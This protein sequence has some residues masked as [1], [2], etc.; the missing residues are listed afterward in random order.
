LLENDHEAFLSVVFD[1]SKK[2]KNTAKVGSDSGGNSN[3]G[4]GYHEGGGNSING[5]GAALSMGS[6]GDDLRCRGPE[7][8]RVSREEAVQLQAEAAAT[9]PSSQVNSAAAAA[10]SAA[11]NTARAAGVS[12]DQATLLD[13]SGGSSGSSVDA[14]RSHGARFGIVSAFARVLAVAAACAVLR[15]WSVAS[16]RRRNTGNSSTTRGNGSGDSRGSNATSSDTAD[17]SSS[18]HQS[19]GSHKDNQNQSNE[20]DNDSLRRGRINDGEIVHAFGASSSFSDLLA[21]VARALGF[22]FGFLSATAKVCAPCD[23]NE[24]DCR[25]CLCDMKRRCVLLALC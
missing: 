10:A 11:V 7:L 15:E 17:S 6:A 9:F 14:S 25:S 12:L 8:R 23:D 24:T 2:K 16:H 13:G 1:D 4:S 3:G 21:N 18:I 5:W 19:T 20:D 22:G